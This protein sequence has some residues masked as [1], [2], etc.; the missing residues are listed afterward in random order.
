MISEY[1]SVI[2]LENMSKLDEAYQASC[3]VF[4]QLED[5][6]YVFDPGTL[7]KILMNLSFK[8][9]CNIFS[10]ITFNLIELNR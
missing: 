10:N 9:K 2:L 3:E 1:V 7:L 4:F 6:H 5:M 8:F